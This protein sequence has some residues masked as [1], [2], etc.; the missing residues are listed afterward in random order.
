[1]YV[2][3]MHKGMGR[4]AA[5]QTRRIETWHAES[6]PYPS[7]PTR[8]SPL[9]LAQIA[10]R[11]CQDRRNQVPFTSASPP[12]VATGRTVAEGSAVVMATCVL[13]G[14]N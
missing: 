4:E 11:P 12:H 9:L 13:S 3:R 7:L 10:N 14:E 8:H 6:Q 2:W 5:W 1:M